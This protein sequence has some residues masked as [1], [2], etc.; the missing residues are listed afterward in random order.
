MSA[1][2]ET[3]DEYFT[4]QELL[5]LRQCMDFIQSPTEEFTKARDTLSNFIASIITDMTKDTI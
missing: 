5:F 1:E 3:D 4:I 2:E